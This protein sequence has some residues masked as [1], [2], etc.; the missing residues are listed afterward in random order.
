[1]RCRL[2]ISCGVIACILSGTFALAEA[3]PALL[4]MH[5]NTVQLVGRNDPAIDVLAM[6]KAV[7]KGGSILLKGEFNFG[8]KGSVTITKDVQIEG[9]AG[10]RGTLSAV[11]KGGQTS[12]RSVLP[13]TIS[14][15][16]PKITIK[17]I[18]I[19]GL[20]DGSTLRSRT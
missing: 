19:L 1:M 10:A 20:T 12:F 15:A 4:S 9:K 7:G 18:C 5:A 13:Y 14:T 16:G 17:D 8:E 6:Q 3:K 2:P 11:I